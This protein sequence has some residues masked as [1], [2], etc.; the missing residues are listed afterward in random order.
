MATVH[1]WERYS[2]HTRF[3]DY[4]TKTSISFSY[5]TSYDQYIDNYKESGTTTVTGGTLTK[6]GYVSHEGSDWFV[7]T[8]PPNMV[9]RGAGYLVTS[10]IKEKGIYVDT[11]E[12][13]NASTYPTNGEQGSYWYVYIGSE[14]T[15]ESGVFAA[16][17]GVQKKL[18]SLPAMVDGVLRELSSLYSCVDGVLREV[19]AKAISS[20]LPSGYTRFEYIESTGTQYIDTRYIPKSDDLE[21]YIKF[22]ITEIKAWKAICGS[23]TTGDGP[24]SIAPLTNANSALRV[25]VGNNSVKTDIPVLANEVYELTCHFKDGVLTY[26]CNGTTGTMSASGSVDKTK[27]IYIFTLNSADEGNILGQATKMRLYDF[28]IRDNGTLAF[29]SLP[30][31]DDAGNLGVYDAIEREFRGNSGTG[32]FTGKALAQLPEGYTLLDY[33]QSS[34]T[35]YLN[36]NYKPNHNTRIVMDA[37]LLDYSTNTYGNSF[38]GVRSSGNANAFLVICGK[39]ES[40]S[41]TIMYGD[42]SGNV[43]LTALGRHSIDLNKNVC[44]IDGKAV[45]LTASTFNS[46]YPCYLFT[47]NRTGSANTGNNARM[48]LYSC[49][50]YDNDSLVRDYVPCINPDGEVGMYDLVTA[51]F[52]PNVGAGEFTYALAA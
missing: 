19:F 49:Q 7:N 12:S 26:N 41:W 20:G 47:D 13:E 48:K 15:F 28:W 40:P 36:T 35:Q 18:T 22:S 3:G 46:D 14:E 17:D 34:G 42:A 24:W 44:T 21:I 5:G 2:L 11:V 30:Y 33:I 32:S 29:N 45:T 9:Y 50:I 43:T 23:E 4:D 27:P 25:Y 8:I 52:Y 16:V 31:M 6:E 10:Y 37:D 39:G 51:E 1:K 38:F